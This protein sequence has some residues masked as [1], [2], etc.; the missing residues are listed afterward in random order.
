MRISKK[1]KL[2]LKLSTSDNEVLTSITTRTNFK[3]E[4]SFVRDEWNSL[5]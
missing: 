3:T 5:H 2:K 1:R 4:W